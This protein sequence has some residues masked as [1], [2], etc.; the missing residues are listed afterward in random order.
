MKEQSM[1]KSHRFLT[2]IFLLAFASATVA[3]QRG[4]RAMH[5]ADPGPGTTA[6]PSTPPPGSGTPGAEQPIQNDTPN[7]ID[8]VDP[9]GDLG[10]GPAD[11]AADPVTPTDVVDPTVPGTTPDP[12]IPGTA[13]PGTPETP[14]TVQPLT[15]ASGEFKLENMI[16]KAPAGWAL[17]QDA[18]ASGTLIMGFAKGD[19]YIRIYVKKQAS[20]TMAGVF[21]NGTQTTGP[22]RTEDI[23]GFSWKR[24]DTTGGGKSIAAFMADYQG[25]TYFGFAKSANAQTAKTALSEFLGGMR[26]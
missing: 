21:A 8:V 20:M 7:P 1:L 18:Q 26:R 19:D 11:D 6:P 9:N 16:V 10:G 2:L 17:H 13:T 5:S 25:H 22:E 14:A 12:V 24:L 4:T 15:P 3:C 23:A